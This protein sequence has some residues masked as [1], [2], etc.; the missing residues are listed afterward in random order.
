VKDEGEPPEYFTM[1][2]AIKHVFLL[3]LGEFSLDE[4]DKGD[5][6]ITPYLWVLFVVSSFLLQIHFLN[7]L[8]AIMGETFSKN[9]EINERARV[10]SHL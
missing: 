8:I 3:S 2:G 6:E 5:G 10:K 9:N 7:M 1:I 4:Y